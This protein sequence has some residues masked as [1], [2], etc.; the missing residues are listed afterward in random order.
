MNKLIIG[1]IL[2]LLAMVTINLPRLFPDEWGDAGGSLIILPLLA[3]DTIF[4]LLPLT[5][6]KYKLPER[7]SVSTFGIVLNIG[8]I[9]YFLWM[10]QVIPT[11]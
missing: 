8:I 2:L 3:I 7:T 9:L 6:W 10:L 4:L 5:F 1:Y 11:F